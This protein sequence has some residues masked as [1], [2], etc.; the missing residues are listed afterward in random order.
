MKPFTKIAAGIFALM[1]VLHVLRLAFGW[2]AMIAG[3][4]LPSMAQSLC[5]SS[6]GRTGPYG[7][8]RIPDLKFPSTKRLSELLS[9]V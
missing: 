9:A 5:R 2:E 4:G 1:A 6:R 7:L 3:C 8:A